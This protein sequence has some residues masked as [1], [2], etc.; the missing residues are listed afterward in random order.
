MREMKMWIKGYD[1]KRIP[2]LAERI[3]HTGDLTNNVA[4]LL[5]EKCDSHYIP[6]LAKQLKCTTYITC[7]GLCYVLTNDIV[8]LLIK[9]CDMSRRQDLEEQLIRCEEP[10]YCKFLKK[11]CEG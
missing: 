11:R 5:I 1:S 7:D 8:K 4:K 6:E 9:K 2:S 10:D 3:R